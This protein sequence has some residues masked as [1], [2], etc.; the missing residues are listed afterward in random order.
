MIL[1]A[2]DAVCFVTAQCLSGFISI[3]SS[4]ASFV[5]LKLSRELYA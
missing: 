5:D 2:T 1:L 3:R 4:D